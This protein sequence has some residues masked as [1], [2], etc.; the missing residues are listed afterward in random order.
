MK[1]EHTL[2][3]RA[4]VASALG[5]IVGVVADLAFANGHGLLTAS[6]IGAVLGSTIGWWI[7][8]PR[9]AG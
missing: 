6:V 4:L 8:Q 3:L 1:K 2:V 5:T 9:G 7:F